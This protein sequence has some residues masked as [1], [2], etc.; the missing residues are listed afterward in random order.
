L[1]AEDNPRNYTNQEIQRTVLSFE[2]PSFEVTE[3]RQILPLTPHTN[4]LH[5]L[6]A[7]TRRSRR[8][9]DYFDRYK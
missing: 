8:F 4:D 7:D 9:F 3:R 1:S 5:L 6:D 2:I